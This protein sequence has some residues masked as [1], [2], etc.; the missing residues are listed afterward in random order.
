M[1]KKVKKKT[2]RQKSLTLND[3]VKY[4]QKVLF[5]ALDYKFA[6]IDDKF[7]KIDDKFAKIDDKFAKIDDKFAMMDKRFDGIDKEIQEKFDKIMIGQD[8]LFKIIEDLRS[9]KIAGSEACKRQDQKLEN[10][11]IRIK[12]VEQKIGVATLK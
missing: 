1:A 8:K 5:P 7:A 11:E 10:H 12:V 2:I 4:N 3:L 9:D 6:K